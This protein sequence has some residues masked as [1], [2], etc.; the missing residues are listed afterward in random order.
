MDQSEEGRARRELAI[1][2]CCGVDAD[3]LGRRRAI[4]EALS[5]VFC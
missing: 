1:A 4:Q 3:A 2:A 5:S